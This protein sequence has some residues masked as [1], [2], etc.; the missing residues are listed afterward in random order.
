V[1]NTKLKRF[2]DVQVGKTINGTNLTLIVN[3]NNNILK[4]TEEQNLMT[5]KLIL[6]LRRVHKK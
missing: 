1:R 2:I 6:K 5:E 3:E 4:K